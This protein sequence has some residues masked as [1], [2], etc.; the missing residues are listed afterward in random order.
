[1][2]DTTGVDAPLTPAELMALRALLERDAIRRVVEGYAR[3]IDRCD[4]VA[5]RAAYWDDAYDDHGSFK[6][7]AQEFVGWALAA[8]N[9]LSGHQHVLGQSVITVDG[10]QASCETYFV[11]Y[12]EEGR[13]PLPNVVSALAGRYVDSLERRGGEWKIAHRVVV[14]DWSTVWRS[15]ERFATVEAFAAGKWY[16]A[17]YSC[18]TSLPSA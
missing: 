13:S 9:T 17:D 14:I 8:A 2:M 1:M 16:P 10:D 5:T 6:G 3:G 18:Q 12:A 7:N 11:Y 15:D 4:E